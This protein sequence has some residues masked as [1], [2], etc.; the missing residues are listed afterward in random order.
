M[1][2]KFN[3]V[4]I[5][6]ADGSV[7]G[8]GAGCGDIKRN[9]GSYA[10]APW[11]LSV[12]TKHEAWVAYNS[13]FLAECY[14]DANH[15]EAAGV[16]HN[17]YTIHW[18]PCAAHVPEFNTSNTNPTSNTN[19]KENT[20]MNTNTNT[21]AFLADITTA[22]EALVALKVKGERA[23]MVNALLAADGDD[24]RDAV[25]EGYAAGEL[26]RGFRHFALVFEAKG[27]QD[28]ADVFWA[29]RDDIDEDDD[30]MFRVELAEAV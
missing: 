15:D 6:M 5:N 13:D 23:D 14:D 1:P 18:L 11:G 12:A 24:A 28:T 26:R 19:N 29:L 3:I 16:C 8:H 27:E 4:L 22:R 17:A 21:N 10:D 9:S 20:A 25:V 30:T 7:A 2:S